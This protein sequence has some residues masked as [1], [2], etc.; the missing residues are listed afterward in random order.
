[1]A[2]LDQTSFAALLKQIYPDGVP[3]DLAM[4]NH[5]YMYM[6]GKYDD[7]EGSTM[8]IPI[9][10]ENPMGRSATFSSAQTNTNPS[11]SEKWSLPIKEDHGVITIDALTIRKSRS[12]M[13]AFVR[14]RQTE[15]DMM[16]QQLGNS[17]SH[18]MYR[19][20]GGSLGVI[21]SPG[22]P[23]GVDPTVVLTQREDSRFFAV[24]QTLV[25][26]PNEDGTSLRGGGTGAGFVATV[27][28]VNETDGEID[29]SFTADVLID[30]GDFMFVQG[31]PTLKMNGIASYIPLVAPTTGDNFL[32]VDR[33]VQPT[34]LAGQ[35]RATPGTTIK[36]N[37]LRITEEIVRQ[38]GNPGYVFISHTQFSNL[39]TDLGDNF[40]RYYG[41]GG[42]VDWGWSYVE[43]HT[44]AGPVKVVPDAD[45]DQNLGYVLDMDTWRF[46]HLDGFPHIDTID[47][48]NALRQSNADGIEVRS[49]YWGN[50]TCIAPGR[51]GVFELA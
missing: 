25:F 13:G 43:V 4:K 31:D 46:H 23:L 29:L 27:T 42:S 28:K 5:P 12:N 11:Q 32:G 7:F 8:E 47:G 19:D 14:A 6:V 16:L 39:V 36:E 41:A 26:G 49:R 17:A 21:A 18:A 30:A 15:I 1:M 35:R 9:Y 33:S 51:N 34:R 24:G 20:P 38:G 50:L 37:I 44:S 10:F 48:N 22:T 3:Y 2:G 45:C 40:V